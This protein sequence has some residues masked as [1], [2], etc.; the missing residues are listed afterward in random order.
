MR[1]RLACECIQRS[2]ATLLLTLCEE[3]GRACICNRV[4]HNDTI[5]GQLLRVDGGGALA[6]RPP[7]L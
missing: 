4:P 1:E 2:T 5:W 7:A 6:L 3:N